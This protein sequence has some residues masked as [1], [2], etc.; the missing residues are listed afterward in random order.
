MTRDCTEANPRLAVHATW[1]GRFQP[2]HEGHLATL[3]AI[4]DEFAGPVCLMLIQSTGWSTIGPS[5]LMDAQHARSK[6]PFTIWERREMIR[7]VLEAEGLLDRVTILGIPRPDILW[8]AVQ[9]FYP[10]RRFIC[11]TDR[12]ELDEEKL[13][14]WKSRGES[15]MII[16]TGE[17]ERSSTSIKA[18]V[19]RGEDWRALLHPA[20][21]DYF[22]L[23]DGPSRLANASL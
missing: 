23:I 11:L 4:L 16:K 12:D 7:L 22:E 18:A 14:V 17:S 9:G 13:N 20:T 15:V 19:Q 8:E 5:S 10:P 1:A 6:N 3:C 2:F 21:L